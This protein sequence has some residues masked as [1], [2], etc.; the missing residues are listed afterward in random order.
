MSSA[1][2]QPLDFTD[3]L[4]EDCRFLNAMGPFL[5]K[6]RDSRERRAAN[7]ILKMLRLSPTLEVCEALMAGRKVHRDR[8]DPYWARRYGL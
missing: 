2:H 8:L 6:Y 5:A 1:A 7:H 4:C 3:C